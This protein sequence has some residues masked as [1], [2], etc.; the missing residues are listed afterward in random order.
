MQ[1]PA[2]PAP[3]VP[4]PKMVA[5]RFNRHIDGMAFPFRGRNLPDTAFSGCSA[6]TQSDSSSLTHCYL[7]ILYRGRVGPAGMNISLS[8]N[9]S[10][11]PWL[12]RFPRPDE[13]GKS[14]AGDPIPTPKA[15]T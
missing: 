1:L 15:I 8:F 5:Y 13:R 14:P 6:V 3:D 12:G 11:N 4:L 7:G 9:V 10:W 2:Q